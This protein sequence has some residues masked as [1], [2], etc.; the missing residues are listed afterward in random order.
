MCVYRTTLPVKASDPLELELQVDCNWHGCWEPIEPG[1]QEKQVLLTIGPSSPSVYVTFGVLLHKNLN[2]IE[3]KTFDVCNVKITRLLGMDSFV[4]LINVH[5]LWARKTKQKQKPNKT[6]QTKNKQPLPH[7]ATECTQNIGILEG[8]WTLE[9]KILEIWEY[10]L[11]LWKGGLDQNHLR[12]SF[13][14]RWSKNGRIYLSLKNNNFN[15]YWC[16]PS[17][18]GV[19]MATRGLWS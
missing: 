18:P 19:L 14:K 6:N 17:M 2:G 9:S 16:F 11:I 1:L 3:D 7:W 13:H 8:R 5:G 15:V 12:G 10:I 4:T